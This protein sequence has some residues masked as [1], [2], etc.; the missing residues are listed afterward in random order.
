MNPED[1]PTEIL[2][3]QECV[4]QIAKMIDEGLRPLNREEEH[5][6]AMIKTQLRLGGF[7]EDGWNNN[8]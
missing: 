4:Y 3:L 5:R 2:R 1:V 6:M 7:I 8:A